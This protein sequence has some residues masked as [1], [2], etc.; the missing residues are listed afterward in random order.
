[1]ST[2]S[3]IGIVH[4]N[5]FI[6]HIYCHWDGYPSHVGKMLLEHY[7][8]R[9]KVEALMKLGNISSLN[10]DIGEKHPFDAHKD[11]RYEHMCHAYG[12]DRGD[13]GV[14]AVE[15]GGEYTVTARARRE[16][17]EYVY[18]FDL[19]GTWKFTGTWNS[20]ALHNGFKFAPLTLED[21]KG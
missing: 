20:A 16:G 17:V 19:N 7:T 12:R 1:M 5:G 14:C 8:D 10:K 15:S 18:L 4:P 6:E 3:R 2:R 11:P 13:T 21:C 9:S